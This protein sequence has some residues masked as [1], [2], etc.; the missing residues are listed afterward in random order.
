MCPPES[1]HRCSKTFEKDAQGFHGVWMVLF[2]Y[3]VVNLLN[4]LYLKYIGISWDVMYNSEHCC[5]MYRIV[6]KIVGSIT[7][8]IFCLFIL[9][10]L[11]G[12][13]TVS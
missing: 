9:L 2:L 3:S 13:M 6:V 4:S 12:M 10:Y 8:R 1:A 11:C 7:K 5:M